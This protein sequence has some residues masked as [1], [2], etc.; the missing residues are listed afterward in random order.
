MK[1]KPAIPRIV[2]RYVAGA[3]VAYGI[4]SAETAQ[5]IQNDPVISGAVATAFG[6]VVGVVTEAAYGLAKRFGW[7]T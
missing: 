5:V 7:R 2:L 4:V 3:L 1:I 6:I